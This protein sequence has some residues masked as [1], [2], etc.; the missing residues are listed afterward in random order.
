M[1]R[2]VYD[3]VSTANPAWILLLIPFLALGFA[4]KAFRKP[5]L[6]QSAEKQRVESHVEP[7]LDFDFRKVAPIKYQPYKTQGHVT[8]GKEFIVN[9]TP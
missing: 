3:T 6:K 9:A 5:Q 8:M 2:V 4:L 7:L 1:I